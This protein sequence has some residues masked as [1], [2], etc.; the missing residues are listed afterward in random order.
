[1]GLTTIHRKKLIVTKIAIQPRT[2][3]DF[4]DKRHKRRNMDMRFGTWNARSLC[5]A[6]S[7]MTVS[8]ELARYKLD[9]M[10]MQEVRWESSGTEPAEEYTFSTE[11]EQES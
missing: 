6:G 1:V 4:S 8:S 10:R 2:L 3:T 11:G 7:V 9:L 5:R